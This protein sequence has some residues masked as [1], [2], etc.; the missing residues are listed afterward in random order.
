MTDVIT[1]FSLYILCWVGLPA[2]FI[3]IQ[4]TWNIF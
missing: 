3:W 1:F 2:L 4:E